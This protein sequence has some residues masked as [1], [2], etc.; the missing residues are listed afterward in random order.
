MKASSLLQKRTEKKSQGEEMKMKQ[1]VFAHSLK[2][3]EL[4]ADQL[5]GVKS[6]PIRLQSERNH[7]QRTQW[8]NVGGS[9]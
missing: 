9:I 8:G 2:K 3:V 1:E 7:T 6:S 5:C 4:V